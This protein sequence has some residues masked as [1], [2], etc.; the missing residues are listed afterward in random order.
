MVSQGSRG[1]AAAADGARASA[2]RGHPPVSPRGA[3][4][5]PSP[6]TRSRSLRS[7]PGPPPRRALAPPVRVALLRPRLPAGREERELCLRR[8]DDRSTA[9]TGHPL[10]DDAVRSSVARSVA[11]S[12]ACA[13][14]R[15]RSAT[16]IQPLLGGELVER[17]IGVGE[18]L[19]DTVGHHAR[20]QR[21][22]PGLDRG[23][24]IRERERRGR[25]VGETEPPLGIGGPPRQRAD[26]GCR[27]RRVRGTAAARHRRT[28]PATPPGSPSGRRSTVGSARASTRPATVSVSPAACP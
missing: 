10:L 27:R 26:P 18:R 16:G 3:R 9:P 23:A 19:L 22:D 2:P 1:R 7:R 20:P 24:A 25:P 17:Q 6:R 14:P 15:T 21:G 8:D 4:R 28:T 12:N 13:T 11:P 5:A